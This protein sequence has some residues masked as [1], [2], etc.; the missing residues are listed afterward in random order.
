MEPLQ[1]RTSTSS[2]QE[3]YYKTNNKKG[4]DAERRNAFSAIREARKPIINTADM[5][6]PVVDPLMV[7]KDWLSLVEDAIGDFESMGEE[8]FSS[9][10]D[11]MTLFEPRTV[12]EMSFLPLTDF[13]RRL[14]CW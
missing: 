1:P 10:M 7:H 12:E 2:S 13:S 6:P 4:L 11:S 3:Q 8:Y 9:M 5:P 14:P